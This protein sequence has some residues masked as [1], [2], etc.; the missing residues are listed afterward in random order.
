[1]IQPGMEYIK[2]PEGVDFVND[3]K[4]HSELGHFENK[5]TFA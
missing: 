3:K 5:Y 2:E 1:M 4:F